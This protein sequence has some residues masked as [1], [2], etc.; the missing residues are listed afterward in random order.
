MAKKKRIEFVLEAPHAGAVAAAG[1]F[2]NWD[3]S[4]TPM[5]RGKDGLWRAKEILPPGRHEYRFVVDG[6]WLS[7]PKA[8]ESVP[9][10]HGGDNSVMVVTVESRREST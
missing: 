2:N 9:N 10:P 1:T 4:L 3:A 8:K 7:D 5:K 6:Q